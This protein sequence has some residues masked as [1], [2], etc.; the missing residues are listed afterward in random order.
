MAQAAGELETGADTSLTTS[1]ALADPLADGTSP[2]SETE[3]GDSDAAPSAKDLALGADST[4]GGPEAAPE[5][6]EDGER[7]GL[8]AGRQA[9]CDERVRE[10]AGIPDAQFA[11][12]ALALEPAFEL[13]ADEEAAPVAHRGSG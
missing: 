10:V 9:A 6:A 2:M 5:T 4:A 13:D 8:A 12:C 7:V 1:V 11:S 3:D